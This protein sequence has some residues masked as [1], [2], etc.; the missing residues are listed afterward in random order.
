[1]RLGS[2]WYGWGSYRFEWTSANLRA[3]CSNSKILCTFG[4][5]IRTF[6]WLLTILAATVIVCDHCH[7]E[8][9]DVENKNARIRPLFA[10]TFCYQLKVKEMSHRP[11]LV[12]AVM[13]IFF[14]LCGLPCFFW[15][16]FVACIRSLIDYLFTSSSSVCPVDT[17]THTSYKLPK[18]NVS[19]DWFR[20]KK[21]VFMQIG[22]IQINI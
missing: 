18:I 21:F 15:L 3:N 2:F 6:R 4:F 16:L 10:V 13:F 12:V 11:I 14:F 19:C 9:D 22:R 17:H 1:M 8:G 5:A 7:R 20:R